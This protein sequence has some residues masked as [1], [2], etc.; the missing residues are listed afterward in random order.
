MS[1]IAEFA[2]QLDCPTPLFAATIP[3]YTAAAAMGR[4]AEDTAAVCAV[5]E[6]MANYRRTP[7]AR[8][9]RARRAD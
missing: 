7:S 5:L 6:E 1:V 9:R 8:R 2:R 3:L 4:E